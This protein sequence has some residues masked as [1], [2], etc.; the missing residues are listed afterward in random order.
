MKN[1]I[2]GSV[3]SFA[4]LS[5]VAGCQKHP[6]TDDTTRA[7]AV[8]QPPAA[9]KAH[10]MTP[11]SGESAAKAQQLALKVVTGSEDGF[12]VNSTLVTGDKDAVLID[13]Q[14]TLADA[15]RVV[16]TIKASGKNLTT[17]Y[18]TH[19]HPD[20][21]F[22]FPAI[23]ASFPSARLVA[24]PATVKEIE[25][26]WEAKV[27]Q[28]Q[29]MYKE[30]ITSKPVIPEALSTN[31]LEL[32]GQKLEIVGGAQGDE[33]ENSYVWLPGLRTVIT[34]D[35]VYDGVYPWTA[36]TTPESRKGW[37]TTLDKL[38]ALKADKV[39][40]GHQKPDRTQSAASI[41]FTKEYLT[42]YDDALGTSKNAAELET[43]MKAKYPDTALPVIV[44]IGAEAAYKPASTKTSSASAATPAEKAKTPGE[45]ARPSSKTPE[46]P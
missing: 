30:K 34:G 40:P 26:T 13:A 10:E 15:Q 4:L 44:K 6:P 25:T 21:Y 1:R 8:E 17:V 27:K 23:Q 43:K 7:P 22:G 42:A 14:F 29:P 20:H 16:D 18:V 36:E 11:S 31:T 5:L 33:P 37:A 39:I 12:L 28:W 9:E 3:L 41:D 2:R 24:L 46:T 19:G 38:V 32:E 45:P 35:I